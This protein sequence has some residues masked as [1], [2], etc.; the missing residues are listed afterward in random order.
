[1]LLVLALAS[2]LGHDVVIDGQRSLAPAQHVVANVPDKEAVYFDLPD[3]QQIVVHTSK[4]FECSAALLD[5]CVISA[6]SGGPGHKS[7]DPIDEP[8]LDVSR[9]QCLPESVDTIVTALLAAKD[10]DARRALAPR[11]DA[12]GRGALAGLVR[13]T[14]DTREAY[15]HPVLLNEAALTNRSPKDRT[16]PQWAALP[17]TV[18]AWADAELLRILTPRYTSPHERRS[19]PF[20]S[21]VF[22]S[23]DWQHWWRRHWHESLDAIRTA[24]QPVVDAYWR[25]GGVEQPLP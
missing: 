23:P 13:Y 5:G 8:Q 19:K 3:G 11:L 21:R 10:D 2:E 24:L 17:V 16:T 18:A 6:H 4:G 1:M 7:A 20:S 25:S 9:W 12:L 15:R 22:R 14:S